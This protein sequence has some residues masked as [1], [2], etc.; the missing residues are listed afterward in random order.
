[1]AP[2]DQRSRLRVSVT[3]EH[4]R[5]HGLDNVVVADAG[6]FVNAGASNPTNTIV[7]VG[8]RNIRYYVGQGARPAA[9]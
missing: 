8:L 1:M 6:V 3:D 9:K 7:A 4:G 5:V 2:G